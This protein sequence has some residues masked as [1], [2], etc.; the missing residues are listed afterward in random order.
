MTY[1]MY[2]PDGR[3]DSGLM[4][5]AII[6]EDN[7]EI[8]IKQFARPEVGA[9]MQVGSHYARTFGYQDYWTTTPVIEITDEWE[10]IDEFGEVTEC[11]RFKTRNSTYVW[12]KF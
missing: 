4:S 3:G 9:C 2:S 10:D 11:V 8:T 6:R 1:S 12:K 7:G 5:N